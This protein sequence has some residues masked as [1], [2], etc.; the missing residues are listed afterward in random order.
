[1]PTLF[2]ASHEESPKAKSAPKGSL[3]EKATSLKAFASYALHPKGLH[4]ET[5]EKEE[6][7]ILFLRQHL[8]FLIP[9]LVVG[10]FLCFVPVV[11]PFFL[12]AFPDYFS[13]SPSYV[14]VGTI[15]WYVAVFGFCLTKTIHWYFNIFIVTNERIVDIDFINLLHKEFSEA[16]VTRIQDISYNTKGLLGTMFNFGDVSIQTAGELPNFI[17]EG[18]PKPSEVVEIIS[19]ISDG[20]EVTL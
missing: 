1:M 20:K 3:R 18:V 12:S 14:I 17:F 8:I 7:I 6:E 19:D 11:F 2:E 15:F 13:L 16:Q 4:F 9:W 5:Q 10:V